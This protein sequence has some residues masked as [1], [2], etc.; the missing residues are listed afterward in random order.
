[1]S[2]VQLGRA[3]SVTDDTYDGGDTGGDTCATRSVENEST[4]SVC[5]GQRDKPNS[6]QHGDFAGVLKHPRISKANILILTD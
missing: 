2:T 4:E 5:Q 3:T 6:M 1:M